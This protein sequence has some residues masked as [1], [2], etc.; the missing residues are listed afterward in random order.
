MHF[1]NIIETLSRQHHI[2]LFVDMDGVIAA[3]DFGRKFDFD[4]KRPLLHHL[5]V[6]EKISHLEQVELYILSI[7]PKEEQIEEKQRWLD[8]YAPFFPQEHRTILAS[9]NYPELSSKEIKAHFLKQVQT[10]DQIVMIDD[11]NA[12]LKYIHHVLPHVLLYQDSELVD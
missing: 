9:T 4:K 5:D 11:D 8:Q 12:V 3:Y 10:E 6:L 1:Y 2:V 7:S